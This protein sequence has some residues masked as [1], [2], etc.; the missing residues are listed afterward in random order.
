MDFAVSRARGVR[1][2]GLV[3]A[4][5][6]VSSAAAAC[7]DR[8]QSASSSG[9]TA[10]RTSAPE[11][12]TTSVAASTVTSSL[13]PLADGTNWKPVLRDDFTGA[14]LDPTHWSTCYSWS[15]TTC[16]N[17]STH[18]LE[19]YTPENVSVAAG[20]LHLTAR[21]E[22][23]FALGRH[24]AYTSGMVSTA[25]PDRTMFAFRYGYIEARARV[26]A[27]AG[28]WSAF[29]L[30]PSNHSALP[31]VDVFEIVGYQPGVALE[32]THWQG[33]NAAQQFGNATA[34]PTAVGG[35]HV[36]GL[37]WEPSSLTWYVDGRKVWTMNN[38]AGVPQQ[39][40]TV[41]ADLA[42]GGPYATAPRGAGAFPATMRFDY[43]K[44]WQH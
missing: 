38:R 21:S 43:V 27:A 24:F 2:F 41:I 14:A 34:L 6:A 29:W 12:T 17:A 10:P 23:A 42:V 30:L 25:R 4:M 5:L 3:F 15:S 8:A 36:Y 19:L 9:L 35:W 40:M 11:S 22:G 18:E 1:N 39:D 33:T 32:F 44:V 16:T 20:E 37:D 31:E 7:T 26:P 13:P 28:L